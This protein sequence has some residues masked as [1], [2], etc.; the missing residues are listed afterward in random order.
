MKEKSIDNQG[1]RL[2][3]NAFVEF[4]ERIGLEPIT[5]TLPVL[6]QK[7]AYLVNN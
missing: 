2:I 5:L 4:V 6:F 1:F 3:V 7:R